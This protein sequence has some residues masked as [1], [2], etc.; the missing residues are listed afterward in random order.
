MTKELTAE[1]KEKKEKIESLNKE[2]ETMEKSLQE[3]KNALKETKGKTGMTW[4]SFGWDF[5]T[6]ILPSFVAGFGSCLLGQAILGG[7]GSAPEGGGE[8]S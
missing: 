1:E 2:I 4:K 8:I 3:K 7:G 5:A 6:K